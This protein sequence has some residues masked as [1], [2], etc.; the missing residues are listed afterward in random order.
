M[1]CV[2]GCQRLSTEGAQQAKY[3]VNGNPWVMVRMKIRGRSG[4]VWE[5]AR[6]EA[7]KIRCQDQFQL[8]F[9]FVE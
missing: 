7:G 6:D 4:G 3:W 5:M 9:A 2:K 8:T 1:S